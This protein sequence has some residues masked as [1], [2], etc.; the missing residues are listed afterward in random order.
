MNI[1]SKK[2][3]KLVALL[4]AFALPVTGMSFGG[5]TLIKADAAVYSKSSTSTGDTG[6]KN[7]VNSS[8]TIR[9]VLDKIT[10]LP[11]YGKTLDSSKR[12]TVE[13]PFVILEIVPYEE[14]AEFGYLVG[15]CE[16]VRVEDMF[17][18]GMLDT[19]R[20]LN[21]GELIKTNE[22]Y[23]F[24]DEKEGQKEYYN[25]SGTET[26]PDGIT[27]NM[28]HKGYY[29]YVG[30][31]NGCFELV[32]DE[33]GVLRMQKAEDESSE[34]AYIWHTVNTFEVA[35]YASVTFNDSFKS[36]EP[37]LGDRI[38]TTR[39]SNEDDPVINVASQIYFCRYKCKESFLKDTLMLS[40]EAASE[41]SCV[42]KT[43]TPDELNNTPDWV[44]YA[45][46]I[47]MYPNTHNQD[48]TKVWK[49]T[50]NGEPVNRL[51]H[52][53]GRTS[54]PL[55]GFEINDI[56]A[57]VALKIFYKVTDTK[58]FA[59]III[60]NRIYDLSQETYTS[61][62]KKTNNLKLKVYDWNLNYLDKTEDSGATCKNNV[63]KLCIMLVC[64]NPNLLR[65]IY[66]KP[67][68]EIIKITD[69]GKLVNTLQTG[70]A[71]Y[72][73]SG[74]TL[75]LCDKNAS[76]LY[77]YSTYI[78]NW[79]AIGS[80]GNVSDS[81]YKNYV[82][83]H[84]YTYDGSKCIFD[85]YIGG[86]ISADDKTTI[87]NYPE[88]E[89]KV[90]LYQDF[91][92]T[93]DKNADLINYTEAQG[94]DS[95]D[96]VRYIL[97][98]LGNSRYFGDDITLRVLDIEPSVGLDKNSKP[99]W[100]L[101]QGNL[102]IL[103]PN[104]AGDF[105]IT[106]QTTAEFIGKTELLNSEYDLIY[107]GLDI[108][109]YNT[110]NGSVTLNNGNTLW[111]QTIT[112]F[113]D[114]YMDG[115]I[116]FHI[117]DKM[118][119]TLYTA[120]GFNG[121]SP[122]FLYSVN[123]GINWDSN[124]LR[125]SGNDITRIKYSQLEDYIKTG[126]PIVAEGYLYDLEKCFID[127][128]S[129][130]YDFVLKYRNT[131]EDVKGVYST[132]NTK[133]LE[134]AVRYSSAEVTINK[135]KLPK[136]YS[137]GYLDTDNG[138]VKL[139]YEFNVPDDGY[140]Y[141]II[142]D[143]NMDSIY[144]L[145]DEIVMTGSAQKGYNSCTY[146]FPNTIFGVVPWRLEI[147]KDSDSIVYAA[148][149]GY[150]AVK[151]PDGEDK[152]I[153]KVLQI[154]PDDGGK[155]NLASNSYKKYY[156]NLDAFEITVDTVTWS[157]FSECFKN[158]GFKY[159]INAAIGEDNPTNLDNV[160][161]VTVNKGTSGEKEADLSQYNMIIIGFG[162]T[163]D[164]TDLDNTNNAVAYLQ[165]Y[166]DLGKSI[167]YTHDVTSMNN[168]IKTFG[169]TANA[170]L[171]DYMGMNRFGS[172]HRLMNINGGVPYFTKEIQDSLIAYQNN[173][174]NYDYIVSDTVAEKIKAGELSQSE[175][176]YYNNLNELKQG[177]TY[178]AMKRMGWTNKT[179]YNRDDSWYYYK[180][181]YKYMIITP[182]NP[183]QY[184]INDS[185]NS[186]ARTTGFSQNY[187]ATSRAT[188]VNDGQI[189]TYPYEISDV[190]PVSK[191]HGQYYQLNM[192]DPEITVW[193]CLSDPVASGNTGAGDARYTNSG[194]GQAGTGLTYGVSPNDVANNYY[195]YSKGNVFYSGVGHF[196][197]SSGSLTDM[198]AKLFVNTMIAAYRV[199]YDIPK[200]EIEKGQLTKEIPGT[201]SDSGFE[202]TIIK[203]MK[204][205][206]TSDMPDYEECDKVRIY[207]R[208]LDYNYSGSSLN[209]KINLGGSNNV[210]EI[211][212]AE[213]NTLLDDVNA[214]NYITGLDSDKL[215]YFY[216]SK[217]IKDIITFEVQSAADPDK[218][219]KALLKLSL[220]GLYDLD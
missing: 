217:N 112:D 79:F 25:L 66:L 26:W 183:N 121:T 172:V 72:Y 137:E 131:D 85:E 38:Y 129:N 153:I 15:G 94:A 50:I 162:D 56:S 179:N 175:I 120:N 189:T 102:R 159:N 134:N 199:S 90:Y 188:K 9:A 149:T 18:S 177:F 187:D 10:E 160:E 180:V 173:H 163:Y 42:I 146:E 12:G 107:F 89:M 123:K 70:D 68:N 204:N 62:T 126:K 212:S 53:S 191:T 125:F 27:A 186:V 197:G 213:D 210:N 36:A 139:S 144:S 11:Q 4:L 116:Y 28:T 100:T 76:S 48:V 19:I 206:Y 24:A 192:E 77:G 31:G 78:E 184:V 143:Q 164:D 218:K 74:L 169:Y 101:G 55:N 81:R 157:G 165:Y 216:C 105:D 203:R 16:P 193:Y 190:L 150:S 158:S 119:S 59:A 23:F 49:S 104:F 75:Q 46:L 97:G 195:I 200:I 198:E 122:K 196:T 220:H 80:C 132:E 103:L 6:L 147:Y 29:E 7:N 108:G 41:Y 60:D 33:A 5:R 39:E 140:S 51:G 45:D 133:L 34:G 91:K 111:N 110:K 115:K 156:N 92:D 214:D 1:I 22:A 124:E 83:D 67:G 185:K 117:G 174:N 128:N 87:W 145:A 96:A 106:H 178:Y 8:T 148:E 43:I 54:Y 209:V 20:S 61:T 86:S 152:K 205:Y 98:L 17:G 82:S 171:L 201:Q 30:S 84:V 219:S 13:Q 170:M 40:D 71:A 207:F 35:D 182:G 21:A 64:M 138:Y 154:T 211:W 47:Y 2:A 88:G 118:M 58:N 63:Y 151:R 44:D 57:E 155:L 113:N 176:D 69:D 142:I 181:P 166:T 202:I 167:M 95:S 141:R 3:K 99:N 136:E 114:N 194:N 161:K 130:I 65:Q 14:C 208:P 135:D 127:I 52:T 73:W 215:Y 93:L 168:T 109:A 32:K 37:V